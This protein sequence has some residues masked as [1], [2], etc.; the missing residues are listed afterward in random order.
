[1]LTCGG[2]RCAWV[3]VEAVVIEVR[4]N[5]HV[6]RAQPREYARK[7]RCFRVAVA[8]SEL[9]VHVCG[10]FLSDRDFLG[11]VQVGEHNAVRVDL[12]PEQSRLVARLAKPELRQNEGSVRS[13]GSLG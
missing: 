2:R 7:Q 11:G 3:G 12:E 1:M 8:P 13:E 9:P 10:G 4:A 6:R 5:R